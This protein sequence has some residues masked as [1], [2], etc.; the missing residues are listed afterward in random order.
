M[1]SPD[2][3]LNA[4]KNQHCAGETQ[5]VGLFNRLSLVRK[6]IRHV[7]CLSELETLVDTEHDHDAD[8]VLRL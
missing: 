4:N 3:T 1:N 8:L 2:Q 6:F 5:E 7:F